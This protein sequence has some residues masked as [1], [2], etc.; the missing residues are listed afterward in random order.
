MFEVTRL[1]KA[2]A[3]PATFTS[4]FEYSV[5]IDEHGQVAQV[6]KRAARSQCHIYI[7]TKD[8][9]YYGFIGISLAVFAQLPAL[10]VDYLFTSAQ[11]RGTVFDELGG[12]KIADHLLAFAVQSAVTINDIAPVRFV[13]LLPATEKLDAYYRRRGF[14]RLD[15]T[16]WVFM[17]VPQV[18]QR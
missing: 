10:V 6:A 2:A 5:D 16:D 18:R 8:G 7:L 4:K 14:S 1:H 13:A 3:L 12:G 11:F 9:Q 17:K 15:S